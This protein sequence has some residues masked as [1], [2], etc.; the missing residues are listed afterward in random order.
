MQE[1]G[2]RCPLELDVAT[3]RFYETPEAL[4]NQLRTIALNAD[5]VDNP[6][7]VYD[8]GVVER[9]EA[10]ECLLEAIRRRGKR[11]EKKFAKY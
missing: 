11:K 3:R 5:D 2:L 1:Y 4:Y 6:Q 8:R 7:A 10:Y 9:Q